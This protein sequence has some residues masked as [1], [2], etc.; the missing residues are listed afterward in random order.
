MGARANEDDL[1]FGVVTVEPIDQQK[2][3]TDMALT[4]V[5]PVA[6]KWVVKPF[7][8]E[9]CVVCDQQDHRLLEPAH[10][11]A[12]RVRKPRPVLDE[13]LRPVR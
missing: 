5:G 10:V 13:S 6:L 7:R 9:R 8:S 4:M 2:V 3:A 11:V 1:L 12:A